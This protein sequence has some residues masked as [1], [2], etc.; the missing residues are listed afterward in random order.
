MAIHFVTASLVLQVHRLSGLSFIQ[1]HV[2]HQNVSDM[3]LLLNKTRVDR[4]KHWTFFSCLLTQY[5]LSLSLYLSLFI[6]LS[7]SLSLDGATS[8]LVL[9][10]DTINNDQ[11]A[12][13][14]A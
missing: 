2:K 7:H 12:H 4:E 8:H 3:H 9:P 11:S 6:S 13:S 10:G 1:T 5:S 14:Q